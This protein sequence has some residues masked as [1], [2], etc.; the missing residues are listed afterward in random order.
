MRALGSARGLGCRDW[1]PRQSPGMASPR[2]RSLVPGEDFGEPP[3]SAR[4]PHAL[5]GGGWPAPRITTSY[6]LLI[7]LM[8][9]LVIDYGT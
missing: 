2:V 3:K 1:H 8:L 9:V 5:P 4:E 6:L 7:V